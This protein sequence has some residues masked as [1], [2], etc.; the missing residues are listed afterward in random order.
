M[1]GLLALAL[2]LEVPADRLVTQLRA[3]GTLI[4]SDRPKPKSMLAKRL[5]MLRYVASPKYR[6]NECRADLLPDKE[7]Y[8]RIDALQSE[9]QKTELALDVATPKAQDLIEDLA[10]KAIAEFSSRLDRFIDY[11]A[12]DATF[13]HGPNAKA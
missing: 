8:V 3:K 12:A 5:D 2:A 7:R 4:F 1:G 9:E 6:P 10:D 11:T 13:Y